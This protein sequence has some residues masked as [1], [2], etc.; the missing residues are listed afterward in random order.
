ML[1]IVGIA[2][3]L[4]P[5]IFSDPIDSLIFIDFHGKALRSC[6]FEMKIVAFCNVLCDEDENDDDKVEFG[7]PAFQG[8][9][10]PRFSMVAG[11]GLRSDFLRIVCLL[12][13][14]S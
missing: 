8:H 4:T 7:T 1:I 6:P 13:K 5:L 11:R 10:F 12:Y 3:T 2:Q 14:K 9:G